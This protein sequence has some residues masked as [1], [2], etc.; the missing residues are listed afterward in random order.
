MRIWEAQ[1]HTD[2]ADP[3]EDADPD[4]DT[5]PDADAYPDPQN[6]KNAKTLIL[7]FSSTR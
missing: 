2:P 3:D 5:D 4:V 7:G 1:K 6:W